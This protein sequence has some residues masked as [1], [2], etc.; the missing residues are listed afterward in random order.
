MSELTDKLREMARIETSV[1][2]SQRLTLNEAADKIDRHSAL[3]AEAM[4][5]LQDVSDGGVETADG[6]VILDLDILR[7][8][9]NYLSEANQ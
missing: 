3:M 2:Y 1:L 8:I 6:E 4:H 5:L 7:D 9:Q